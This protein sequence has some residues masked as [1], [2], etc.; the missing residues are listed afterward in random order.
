MGQI[1]VAGASNHQGSR[2][3][4]NSSVGFTCV[5]GDGGHLRQE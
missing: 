3:G 5:V 4:V 1:V 2:E